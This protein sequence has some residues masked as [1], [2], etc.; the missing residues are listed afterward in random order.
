[1][2]RS[3]CTL[4]EDEVAAINEQC[5]DL[6]GEANGFF[7]AQDFEAAVE[8][9]TVRKQCKQ[10]IHN[11]QTI[12]ALHC[13]QHSCLGSIICVCHVLQSCLLVVVGLVL[14]NE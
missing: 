11:K 3:V 8:K 14:W 12:T 10:T 13:K 7:A 1:M 9:Y 5:G 4:S 6:K 2:W